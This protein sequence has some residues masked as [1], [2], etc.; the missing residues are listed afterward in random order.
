MFR[1]QSTKNLKNAAASTLPPLP[2]HQTYVTHQYPGRGGT[3][4]SS[5]A[6]IITGLVF[7]WFALAHIFESAGFQNGEAT[8]AWFVIILIAAIVILTVLGLIARW[9]AKDYY[10][11]RVTMADKRLDMLSGQARVAQLLPPTTAASMNYD[12]WRKFMAVKAVMDRAFHHGFIDEQGNLLTPALP[13]STRQVGALQLPGERKPI[14]KDSSLAS[15][16]QGYLI[17]RQILLD[18]RTVNITRFPNLASVE[19]QLVKDFGQPINMAG[20][21]DD[22]TIGMSTHYLTKGGQGGSWS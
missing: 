20:Q 17:D 19:A 18:E 7:F 16:M 8:L 11:Y 10:A 9:L 14:G 2:P 5:A 12:E 3:I 13:W 21:G 22:P 15:W 4:L 6:A 1:K